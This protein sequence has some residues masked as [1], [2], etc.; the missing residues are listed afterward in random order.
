M[1][2][3]LPSI[4]FSVQWKEG[5]TE[6]ERNDVADLLAMCKIHFLDILK[7]ATKVT[8]TKEYLPQLALHIKA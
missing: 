3:E 4:T 5:V 6:D 1:E 8:I 2:P 7:S